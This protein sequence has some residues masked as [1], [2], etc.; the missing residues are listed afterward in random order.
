VAPGGD[1][2]FEQLLEMVAKIQSFEEFF[3]LIKTTILTPYSYGGYGI[4]SGTSAAAPHVAGVVALMLS[5]N[6]K[7][8][9]DQV[10][11]ILQETSTDK[12]PSGRDNRYGYGIVNAQKAVAKAKELAK[13]RVGRGFASKASTHVT[14]AR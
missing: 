7:L 13:P 3:P 2:G 5:V 14:L 6:P 12:G 11:K 10:I 9:R 4:F 1:F 8:T